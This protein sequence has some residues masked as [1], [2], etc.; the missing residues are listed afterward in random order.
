MT[1]DKKILI[2]ASFALA[3]IL[4]C[5]DKLPVPSG[6][7][8]ADEV[9]SNVSRPVLRTTL[10]ASWDENWFASPAVFDLDND[11][12]RALCVEQRWHEKMARAGR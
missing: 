8:T 1:I 2:I 3:L 6:L 4:F 9:P 12:K 10:P 7:N 5:S 11:G